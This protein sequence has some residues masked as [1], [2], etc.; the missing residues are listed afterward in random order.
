[1]VMN[2]QLDLYQ[3]KS[4]LVKFWKCLLKIKNKSIY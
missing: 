3:F 1:M 2:K 4:V